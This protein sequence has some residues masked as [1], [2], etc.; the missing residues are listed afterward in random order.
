MCRRPI[1]P[2]THVRRQPDQVQGVARDRELEGSLLGAESD[3]SFLHRQLETGKR[4]ESL[5]CDHR[6][7][8]QLQLAPVAEA[9]PGPL[10]TGG[11]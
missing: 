2:Q 7:R 4:V 6:T 11:G 3:L 5:Q 8:F 10:L 1:D 9:D